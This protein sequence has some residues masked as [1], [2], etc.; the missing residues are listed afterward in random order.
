MKIQTTIATT[1]FL[2]SVVTVSQTQAAEDLP[3]F[4]E[5]NASIVRTGRPTE[6]GLTKLKNERGIKTIINL[7]D[8]ASNVKKEA[9]W[10]QKLGIEYK[11][12]PTDSF[13]RPDDTK[14][15]EILDLLSDQ[16]RYPILI[17]CKH[18]ED[19][20]GMMVGLFRVFAE[21]WTPKAA[22]QEMLDLG[23]HKILWALDNY[24]KEKTGLR[25]HHQLAKSESLVDMSPNHS[26][27]SDIHSA[28][29]LPELETRNQMFFDFHRRLLR[30]QTE[31][32][33]TVT[34]ARGF[35]GE[36]TLIQ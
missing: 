6:K 34:R 11:S 10:A 7:E 16:T 35:N 15:A 13:S 3:N 23:F 27:K 25:R 8:S 5:V 1:L 24:Y 17:H 18:G 29:A 12:F 30:P 2:F 14:V 26:V 22:Y 4:R 9:A 20:T 28:L 33:A 31:H 36:G 21:Q 19:R 32:K